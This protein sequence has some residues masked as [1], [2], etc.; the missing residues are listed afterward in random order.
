MLMA[1]ASYLWH[2]L[3]A[4]SDRKKVASWTQVIHGASSPALEFT[5]SKH[6]NYKWYSSLFKYVLGYSFNMLS[7]LVS[8]MV[9]AYLKSQFTNTKH[10]TSA[11]Q[12]AISGAKT[13]ISELPVNSQDF[14][15]LDHYLDIHDI[16]SEWHASESR[17]AL[18]I[19]E[20]LKLGSSE[21][22]LNSTSLFHPLVPFF[23]WWITHLRCRTHRYPRTSINK[24]AKVLDPQTCPTHISVPPTAIKYTN[25]FCWQ[26]IDADHP[27]K[28]SNTLKLEEI[29]GYSI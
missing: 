18:I 7:L 23:C 11:Q 27:L 25:R 28:E 29:H 21:M 16:Q 3:A 22:R 26:H 5:Y 20:L 9:L 24:H 2:P 8:S 10:D 4:P 6:G 19:S 14:H 13:G 15:H 1:E 12:R 17:S